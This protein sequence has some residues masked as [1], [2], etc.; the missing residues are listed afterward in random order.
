MARCNPRYRELV[1]SHFW[2]RCNIPSARLDT[3]SGVAGPRDADCRRLTEEFYVNGASSSLPEDVRCHWGKQRWC[4]CESV[5]AA[6]ADAPGSTVGDEV[7]RVP[8]LGE[9]LPFVR[10]HGV[11]NLVGF[12]RIPDGGGPI[13]K[14]LQAFREGGGVRGL[15]DGRLRIIRFEEAKT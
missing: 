11:V 12:F 5:C 7:W 13:P 4:T 15:K 14:D 9:R 8:L 3:A 2:T 10:R 1:N 6:R